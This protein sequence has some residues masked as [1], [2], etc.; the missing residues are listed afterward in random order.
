MGESERNGSEIFELIYDMKFIMAEVITYFVCT[1]CRIDSTCISFLLEVTNPLIYGKTD[2]T[3]Q[4]SARPEQ[5]R[6]GVLRAER[7]TG[8]AAVDPCPENV[9]KPGKVYCCY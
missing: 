7:A 9:T 1:Y 4:D 2:T 5:S 6:T 3:G 8:I